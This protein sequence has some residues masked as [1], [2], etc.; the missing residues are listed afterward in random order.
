MKEQYV[1]MKGDR[2]RHLGGKFI[3]IPSVTDFSIETIFIVRPRE[4]VRVY[5]ED[6]FK[7]ADG[8]QDYKVRYDLCILDGH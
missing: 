6:G 1:F 3:V 8:T 2:I 7:M 4:Y 5:G